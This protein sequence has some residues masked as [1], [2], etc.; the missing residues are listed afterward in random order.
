MEPRLY[1]HRS[2]DIKAAVTLPSGIRWW[3]ER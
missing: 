2:A 1:R 3:I